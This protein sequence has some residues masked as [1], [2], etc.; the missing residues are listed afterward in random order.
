MMTKTLNPGE[1][2]NHSM[3]VVV[4]SSDDYVIV[5]DYDSVLKCRLTTRQKK[6]EDIAYRPGVPCTTLFVPGISAYD[7]NVC[8]GWPLF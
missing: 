3:C 6:N 8:H 1:S 4:G 5:Y 7:S 2:G